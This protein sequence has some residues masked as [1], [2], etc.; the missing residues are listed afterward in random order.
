MTSLEDLPTHDFGH[1]LHALR[2]NRLALMPSDARVVLSGGAAGS[3]YFQWFAN[4]PGQVER[5]I[6]VEYFAPPPDPLPEGVEW[7]ARTLGDLS[8]VGD[9]EVDL[10]FAGQVIEHLWPDD[11]AGFLCE[12]NRVLRPGG[13]IVIDSVTRFVTQRLDWTH[14]EH[15]M[16]FDPDEIVGL[17]ELAGFVDIDIKGVWL[18]YDREREQLLDLDLVGGGTNWPWRRRVIEAEA[19]PQDSFI[20]WAE[21]RKGDGPVDAAAVRRRVGEIYEVARPTAFERVRTDVGDPAGDSVGRRFRAKR[22]TSG[23]V[24]R[25]PG[26]ALPPGRHEAV[27]RLRAEAVDGW[28]SANRTLAE[29]E[30]TRDGGHVIADRSL[31]A[32]D[33]PPGGTQRELALAF[34]LRDTAFD[35][36]LRVRS[37]GAVP[38]VADV[39]VTVN[40]GAGNG[41]GPDARATGPDPARVRAQAAIRSV[42]RA[43]GWPARRLLDPRLQGLRSDN[44]WLAATLG[45][46]ID[47]RANEIAWRLDRPGQTVAARVVA[48]TEHDRSSVLPYVVKALA[49]VVPRSTVLVTESEDDPVPAV[50]ETLGYVV[51]TTKPAAGAR[52]AVAA[53]VRAQSADDPIIEQALRGMDDGRVIVLIMDQFDRPRLEQSLNGWRIDDQTDAEPT[54]EGQPNIIM[55]RAVREPTEPR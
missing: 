19:R 20:W 39:P 44:Q 14:P 54:A 15:T 11:V 47:M 37:S 51:V 33:L 45:E 26:A 42:Q 35:C 31:T 6:G 2:T 30:V 50:L 55:A 5:H 4:Y 53:I 13:A 28:V 21:A 23:F 12:A 41:R 22:G 52:P 36:E 43:A 8:P 46:R 34:E 32:R 16:E 17:M 7:L 27:F 1:F 48:S 49:N 3:L 40:E 9:G 24:L 29:I 18:C 38:L 10:V 25:G